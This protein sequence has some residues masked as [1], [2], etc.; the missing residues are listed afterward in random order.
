M[1]AGGKATPTVRSKKYEKNDHIDH[2]LPCG[3]FRREGN[4]MGNI[5]EESFFSTF[6]VRKTVA[7]V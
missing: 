3:R 5:C 2:N 1:N 7:G 4:V 6:K